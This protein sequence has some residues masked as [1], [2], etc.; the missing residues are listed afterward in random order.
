MHQFLCCLLKAPDI[1]HI[2]FN[3][4]ILRLTN[5][6]AKSVITS[7]KLVKIN[8]LFMQNCLKFM[9]GRWSEGGEVTSNNGSFKA[10]L[11]EGGGLAGASPA[12]TLHEIMCKRQH[13]S[14]SFQEK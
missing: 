8:I 13:L 1:Y 3:G 14:E 11:K 12:V 6:N 4:S 9:H 5:R 10:G 2:K 7:A